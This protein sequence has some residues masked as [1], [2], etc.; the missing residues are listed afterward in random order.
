MEN[1]DIE[2][3]LKHHGIRPT[4][5]RILVYKAIEEFHNPFTLDDVEI[6][7]STMDRSSIFRTLRLFADSEHHI[8]HEVNDGSGFCKY[9]LC[10][11]CGHGNI[12][13]HL[14]F[15][16]KRCKKTFCIEDVEIPEFH[17]PEGFEMTD[18]ECVAKGL[19]SKC[20]KL[21]C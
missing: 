3:M 15:T 19:C 18:I 13:H 5:V 21:S 11:S 2:E 12:H 17:L 9:C 1:N 14:H 20:S 16:C 8:I 7:M 4:A 6:K 10:H